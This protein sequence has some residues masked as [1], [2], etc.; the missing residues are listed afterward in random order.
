[1]VLSVEVD[2]VVIAV[3]D[4]VPRVLTVRGP[5]ASLQWPSGPF[6]ALIDPTLERSLRR[7]LLDQTGLEPG[8]VE[9][10]YTF[11][12]HDRGPRSRIGGARILSIA[13]LV[14]VTEL[15]PSYSA[16]WVDLYEL[17]P[18]EDNREGV[19]PVVVSP[20][21]PVLES[22]AE[23]S[24][25]P[26]TRSAR[27]HRVHRAF[28]LSGAEWDGVQAVDRYDLLYEAGLLAEAK[29]DGGAQPGIMIVDSIAMALNHR[30]ILATVLSRLREKL[31]HRP[32]IAGLLPE[33]FTIRHMHRVMESVA[34]CRL[35]IQGLR[36]LL[37]RS[38][39]V[40]G[41]GEQAQTGGRPAELVRFTT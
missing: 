26:D 3:T 16:G 28:G 17:L 21:A 29:R 12:D 14:L 4:D 36:R 27:R 23:A 7:W 32:A 34:G 19:P 30:R 31:T 10:I 13:Y 40:E 15:D 39:L 35:N 37:D 5:E 24:S 1:M 25:S 8:H 41:T 38:L 22:W 18:W 20:L 2:A 33:A 6:D 11:G 9:Q